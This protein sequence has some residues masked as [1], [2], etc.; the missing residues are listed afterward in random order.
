MVDLHGFTRCLWPRRPIEPTKYYRLRA[1]STPYFTPTIVNRKDCGTL[2]AY[3]KLEKHSQLPRGAMHRVEEVA[4][5]KLVLL[6]SWRW[7]N[8]APFLALHGKPQGR[9]FHSDAAPSIP[10]A[11]R[12]AGDPACLFVVAAGLATWD[13]VWV[14]A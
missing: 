2:A 6:S 3:Q 4:Q 5:S 7:R 12:A 11:V 13:S 14:R 9:G 8:A 10:K 1:A